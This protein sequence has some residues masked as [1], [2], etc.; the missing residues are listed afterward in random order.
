MYFAGKR[1]VIL[2]DNDEPGRGHA[3][4]IAR[5]ISKHAFA[6]TDLERIGRPTKLLRRDPRHAPVSV[7]ALTLALPPGMWKTVT[8]REGTRRPLR[9]PFAAL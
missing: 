7:K 9:S 8:W 4:M 1:V 6:E 2:P 5:S 3:E